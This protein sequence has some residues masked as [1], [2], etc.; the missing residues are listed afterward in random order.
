MRLK[1]FSMVS[2]IPLFAVETLEPQEIA[3]L[4]E[5]TSR[6]LWLREHRKDLADLVAEW[7]LPGV[8]ERRL[9]A[10]MRG[11]RIKRVLARVLDETQFL[12]DYG[13]RSLSKWHKEHPIAAAMPRPEFVIWI[14]NPANPQ[15]APSAAIPIGAAP[16]WFPVNYLIIESL[17]KF[18]HY[19]GDDFKIECP[20]GS[21]KYLTLLEVADE[22]TSRLTKIFLRDV[23][24]SPPGF[25][26]IPK[27]PDRSEFPEQ[28]LV[29][30]IF[31]RRQRPRPRRQPSNRLDRAG[32]QV[33]AT[34]ACPANRPSRQQRRGT[35]L[36]RC[37]AERSHDD[38][39]RHRLNHWV[40]CYHA[41]IKR[42]C[43]LPGRLTGRRSTRLQD[44][45]PPDTLHG[46]LSR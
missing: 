1:S 21:G 23:H 26:P 45:R 44:T 46:H 27:I 20:T 2:L 31:P 43:I 16:I 25:R 17:Q 34:Q 14:T 8:G 41:V 37:S 11:H 32:C 22:L 10:M 18:H 28:P 13:V 9:L 40:L 15:E 24:R 19:Y 39:A 36:A 6:L 30:R 35:Q 33:V 12:S 7:K 3:H 38:R 4:P 42:S 29:S 5:F